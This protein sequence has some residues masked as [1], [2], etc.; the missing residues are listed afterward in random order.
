[1]VERRVPSLEVVAV[2]SLVAGSATLLTSAVIVASQRSQA[3]ALEKVYASRQAEKCGGTRK[4]GEECLSSSHASGRGKAH[5]TDA[6]HRDDDIHED[7]E[8]FTQ[9]VA[10]SVR[11][12]S[13]CAKDGDDDDAP[14]PP[15][16]WAD[17]LFG[18]KE[19]HP[20]LFMRGAVGSVT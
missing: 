2:R 19:L 6:Q 18:P 5:N 7:E 17:A 8:S 11:V 9:G 16:R 20:M 13:E 3:R 4:P 10:S 12:Q 15:Q 1:M 14:P